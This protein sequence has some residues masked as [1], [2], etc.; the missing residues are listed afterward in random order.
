MSF[1]GFEK[2]FPKTEESTGVNKSAESGDGMSHR[3]KQRTHILF[4][5]FILM[6]FPF[7][8][9]DVNT[10]EQESFGG[11][12]QQRNDD[13]DER[14]RGGKKEEWQWWT[15]FQVCIGLFSDG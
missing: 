13:G 3:P 6:F 12:G 14:R 8:D 11:K 7:C 15:R 4:S 2:F 9:S 1:S 10:K 5:V